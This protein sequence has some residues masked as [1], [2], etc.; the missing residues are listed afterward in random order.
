MKR[1]EILISFNALSMWSHTV[2]RNSHIQR[3]SAIFSFGIWQHRFINE[4]FRKFRENRETESLGS[5]AVKSWNYEKITHTN[6]KLWKKDISSELLRNSQTSVLPVTL[7]EDSLHLFWG[8]GL[9]IF[10]HGLIKKTSSHDKKT[11]SLEISSKFWFSMNSE[12]N[13]NIL[14]RI[15]IATTFELFS[16]QGHLRAQTCFLMHQGTLNIHK[17]FQYFLYT[18]CE[19]SG[20]LLNSIRF[21]LRHPLLH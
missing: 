13:Q 4:L 12:G 8:F 14:R 6:S 16:H 7:Y 18:C 15:L 10:C 1:N 9:K 5:G 17:H 21:W 20:R 11:S 2:R 3:F 19:A